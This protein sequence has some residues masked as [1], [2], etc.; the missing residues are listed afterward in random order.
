LT[1]QQERQLIE[2][3]L[4]PLLGLPLLPEVAFGALPSLHQPPRMTAEAADAN[5][6]LS[7]QFNAILCVSRFA[8]CVKVM[9]RDMVGAF[10]TAD[11]I[12]RRL[13][14]WI[15][16][17]VNTAGTGLGENAARYPLREARVEVR[18]RPGRPGV[19]AC[20]VLLQP[21]Y[22]LDAVGAAFRLVTD[23]QAARAA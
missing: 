3:G 14:R 13:Q 23:I 12:Q 8:H 19:F 7:A 22:Q 10:R 9:G 21:H 2:A 18:E 20:T 5:Q 1:D 16:G 4:V 17:F 11:E 15:A 6:A